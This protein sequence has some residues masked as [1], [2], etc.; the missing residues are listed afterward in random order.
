MR[1]SPYSMFLKGPQR[2]CAECNWYLGDS[3]SFSDLLNSCT[4][5]NTIAILTI[6]ALFSEGRK[7]VPL[8]RE[9]VRIAAGF[10]HVR[11][12][13]LRAD[14]VTTCPSRQGSF[15]RGA[16]MRGIGR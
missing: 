10:I 12:S 7:P 6:C 14:A 5:L 8:L 4:I 15:L 3:I 2:I 11:F 1:F 9:Q 13:G 16:M